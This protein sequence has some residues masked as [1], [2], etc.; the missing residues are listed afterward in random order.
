MKALEPIKVISSEAQGLYACKTVLGWCVVGQIGVNKAY[1]KEMKCN[2][3]YVH[4]ANPLK[5]ATRHF[6]LKGP[7]RETDTA[8]LRRMYETD[9][10]EP[11]LQPSTSS[12]KFKEFF[13]NDAR[14]MELMD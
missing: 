14:S 8:M 7:V 2:N 9:F 6:A 3:I 4:E 1:L 13:F 5:R 12:S 11:R 10:R